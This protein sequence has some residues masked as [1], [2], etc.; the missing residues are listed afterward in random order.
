MPKTYSDLFSEVRSAVKIIPLDEV[1]ARLEKR[2]EHPVT[3]VDV[4]EKDEFRAGTFRPPSTPPRLPRA[5]EEIC[6][7]KCGSSFTRRWNPQRLRSQTLAEL[8]TPTSQRNPAT[9]MK[10]AFGRNA[11]G[12]TRRSS[13]AT[14]VTSFCPR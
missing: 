10:V 3:L 14:R 2:A 9:W 1:K 4:R 12:V 13:T 8:A 6:R 11:A 5:A 7:Q